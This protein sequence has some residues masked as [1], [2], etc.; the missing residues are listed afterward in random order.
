MSITIAD[1][2]LLAQL[3]QANAVVELRDPDGN[4]LGTFAVEGSGKLPPGVKSPFTPEEMEARRQKHRGGRPLKDI[5]RDL[6]GRGG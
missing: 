1:P 3:R 6:E 2:G 5:L 4:I